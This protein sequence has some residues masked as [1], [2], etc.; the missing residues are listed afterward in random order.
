M[1]VVLECGVWLGLG[2]VGLGLDGD[3]C[4][5]MNGSIDRSIG[6]PKNRPQPSP[7]PPT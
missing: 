3:G 4:V 2:G 5:R 1:V 7:S 6:K